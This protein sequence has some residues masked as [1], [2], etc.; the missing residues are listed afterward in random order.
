[1]NNLVRRLEFWI[2]QIDCFPAY[3]GIRQDQSVV[4]RLPLRVDQVRM[5]LKDD[6]PVGRADG[7]F[8]RAALVHSMTLHEKGRRPKPTPRRQGYE[9]CYFA[10][11]EWPAPLCNL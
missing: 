4:A 8:I 5:G 2:V 6:K 7:M 9:R 3:H 10:S 1:M 11:G